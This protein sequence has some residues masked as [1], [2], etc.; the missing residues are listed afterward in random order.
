[1]AAGGSHDWLFGY[2]GAGF[3][4]KRYDLFLAVFLQQHLYLLFGVF[5]RLLAIAGE[6]DATF[7]VLQRFLQTQLALFHFLNQGL[8]F[9]E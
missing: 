9:P 6:Q 5:Q 3:T 7:K 1:M 4:V 2:Q 8:E